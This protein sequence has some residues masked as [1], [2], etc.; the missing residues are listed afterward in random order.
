MPC[1]S[2]TISLRNVTKTYRIF[3]HAGERLKQAMTLGLRKYHKEFTALKDVSF[4]VMKGE[5]IGI[6]GRNGAG[7]ST[8][9]QLIC[10]ILKPTSGKV[11]VNGR[12][13]AMLELGAGFN[14][15]FTGRENTYFQGCLM[16]LTE[17]Q[18]KNRFDE[19]EAF[20]NI[21]E[22]IDQP[23]RIYS[24]GMFLRLAFAV[25]VHVEPD[26]LIIDEVLAVGDAVFQQKCINQ[27]NKLQSSGTS[28]VVVSHDPYHIERMCNKAAVLRQGRLSDLQPAKGI[29]SSYHEL[30]QE[31]LTQSPSIIKSCREGTH[32]VSF[33]KVFIE[34]STESD[35]KSVLANEPL[36]IVADIVA[37]QPIDNV[38]FRFE[39]YSSKNELVTTIAS[40]GLT[41]TKQFHGKH[42]ISF[43]MQP[44][45]LTSGWHYITAI[46]GQKFARLDTWQ[47]VVDFKVFL[48][49]H[50]AQ[51]LSMDQG[52]FVSQGQW[53]FCRQP[54]EAVCMDV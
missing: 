29:L 38:R 24:S 31:E 21:G 43:T 28:I 15:E 37:R 45:Q 42:R 54:N 22:F 8:L 36:R 40:I 6:I 3:R 50:K 19:I 53:E 17:A 18:I 51:N 23:V 5:T 12:I 26:V 48:Q 47:R 14:P 9:L 11:K 46:A 41:E 13:S 34:T 1:D 25:A 44:C 20:A 10:G 52:V 7:K 35:A 16:G 33:E 32:E 27:V 4:D 39:L 49:D 30:V 2:I